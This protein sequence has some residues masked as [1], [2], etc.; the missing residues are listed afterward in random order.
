MNKYVVGITGND[1]DKIVNCMTYAI[2]YLYSDLYKTK[3][4]RKAVL[5]STV[6]LDSIIN[7]S[8][9]SIMNVCGIT[10]TSKD[11][12]VKLADLKNQFYK[13]DET[14]LY[15]IYDFKIKAELNRSSKPDTDIYVFVKVDNLIEKKILEAYCADIIFVSN[16]NKPVSKLDFLKIK[17]KCF[18]DTI[19]KDKNTLE[20]MFTGKNQYWYYNN[21]ATPYMKS[22]CVDYIIETNPYFS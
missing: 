10:N 1:F 12:H 6:S 7:E 13:F 15:N 4:G 16:D 22:Y 2:N 17:F 3:H 18:I 5:I 19:I 21:K 20:Y 11:I 8:T 14:I 9:S